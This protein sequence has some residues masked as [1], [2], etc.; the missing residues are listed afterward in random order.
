MESL[1][2]HLSRFAWVPLPALLAGIV[3][4][5]LTDVNLP[6]T[7]PYVAATLGFALG[8]GLPGWAAVLAARNFLQNGSG[9]TLLIG[10]GLLLF[11]TS[12]LGAN[13]AYYGFE[14]HSASLMIFATGMGIAGCIHLLGAVLASVVSD[15]VVPSARLL[16]ICA[17]GSIFAITLLLTYIALGAPPFP[18]LDS[19]SERTIL[20][21]ALLLPSIFLLSLTSLILILLAH[22]RV[23][24]FGKWYG[25]GLGLTA[26]GL[27][28]LALSPRPETL[29][30]S[31]SSLAHYLG[32][33]YLLV[34]VI[35]TRKEDRQWRPVSYPALEESEERFRALAETTRDA[36]AICENGRII[37]VNEQLE[38]MLDYDQSELVGKPVSEV[39]PPE[40]AT[41]VLA[42]L[43]TEGEIAIE[44][45]MTRKHGARI[46]VESYGRTIHQHDRTVQFWAMRDIT[47]RK[48]DERALRESE[49]ELRALFDNMTEGLGVG[50]VV[51]DDRGVPCDLRFLRTNHAFQ[52]HM[53]LT[54]NVVGKPLKKV[55]PNLE[56]DWI[57]IFSEVAST[58]EPARFEKFNQDTSRHYRAVS[59]SPAEGKFA[60]LFNDITKEKQ[61]EEKLRQATEE[62]ARN[63]AKSRA[64]LEQMTEGLIIFDPQGHVTEE[65]QA[66]LRMH[67]FK[68]MDEVLRHVGDLAGLFSLFELY[69]L[70]GNPLPREDW[71]ISRVLRGESFDSYV[72]Q[73]RRTDTGK[74]WI[75][76]LGGAPVYDDEG[77]MMVA[78]FTI[79]DFTERYEMELALKRS[80]DQLE[81]RVAE[82]TAELQQRANQLARLTSELTLTEQRE[83]KRL[84]QILHD[85][86]QQLLVGAKFGLHR[87]G[88]RTPEEQGKAVQEVDQLLT[89]SIEA[90]RSLTVELSPPILHE[91]GLAA[92]M[93][94]LARWMKS[95][96]GLTVDLHLDPTLKV[97][98]EDLRLLFFQAIRELL[99]NVSKHA[100][101]KQARLE[102]FRRDDDLH[103]VVAD[104]GVG[105]DATA[106]FGQREG[107]QEGF[108]LFSIRERLDLI[109]GKLEIVSSPGQGAR[110]SLIAPLQ[111]QEEPPAAEPAP[112]LLPAPPAVTE[113]PPK[114]RQQTIKIMLVDDHAVVRQGL[115]FLL[116]A[117]K[118]MEITGEAADGVTAIARARQLRPDVILMDFSMPRMDGVEATRAIHKEMPQIRIIGL[119]MYE[120]VDR[121]RAMVEAGAVTYLSKSGKSEALISTIRRVA[122]GP[123]KTPQSPP[124][125]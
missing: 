26:V 51:F 113:E 2:R 125:S 118:D 108:G 110:F 90:S 9:P 13:I 70:E 80:R 105:L 89:E 120:E 31:I 58:G 123:Q 82:R 27:L 14:R 99:F 61:D 62:N 81:Q 11:S 10:S 67:G 97:D 116:S 100:G 12:S 69:D 52:Q 75:G 94:W 53:G 68:D 15:W 59:Y 24:R 109:G 83:R 43:F 88:Q 95:T 86:L 39:I 45:P 23:W 124:Y 19:E 119:S 93:E 57:R 121:A 41:Q 5:Q 65:N 18:F 16:L 55:L 7:L 103:A 85:H 106:V 107:P 78:I 35:Q 25:L 28:G 112:K 40:R 20:W 91:A 50:E 84:A 104:R 114:D 71:P 72:I 54:E 56:D 92:S 66:A 32:A 63:L 33:A 21:R 76:A 29:V 47:S 98:R 96:H 60:V 111:T 30:G 117:R 102:L 122:H 73:I 6:F 1:K 64:I 79:R 37:N 17:C 115:S 22:R 49:E 3:L 8:S 48:R 101:V 74:S 87:L 42:G 4:A 34:A 46:I 77:N 44:H 36:V 38:D